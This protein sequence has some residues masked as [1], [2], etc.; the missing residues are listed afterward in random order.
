MRCLLIRLF[1]PIPLVVAVPAVH[2]SLVF[3]K[4]KCEK[5]GKAKNH[6]R[7]ADY[8]S[9][10]KQGEKAARYDERDTEDDRLLFCRLRLETF[11]L[12]TLDLFLGHIPIQSE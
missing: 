8:R 10:D 5:K 2:L 9:D 3:H 11:T 12:R 1:E 7:H 4:W 6:H